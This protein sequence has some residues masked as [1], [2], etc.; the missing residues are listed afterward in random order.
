MYDLMIYDIL[1]E[2]TGNIKRAN[3]E[4]LKKHFNNELL[5]G[6]L[7]EKKLFIIEYKDIDESESII[8]I[9]DKARLEK[10]EQD[11]FLEILKRGNKND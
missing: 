8:E 9:L 10:I 7:T 11:E 1:K 6:Y 3:N 5:K 2:D 4:I